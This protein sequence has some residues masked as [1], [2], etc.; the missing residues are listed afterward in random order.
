MDLRGKKYQE[1]GENYI[2]RRF[3]TCILHLS[4]IRIIKST[5]MRWMGRMAYMVEK[6]NAHRLL[7]RRHEGERPLG[8]PRH[9]WKVVD[10]I[11]LAQDW[12][13]WQALVNSVMNFQVP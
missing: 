11:F 3:I 8:R 5:K 4:I 10:W 7:V 13:K 6:R 9:R 1:D 2:I 12:H